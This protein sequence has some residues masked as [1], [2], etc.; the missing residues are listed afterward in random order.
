MDTIIAYRINGGPVQVIMD[1]E[2]KVGVFQDYDSALKF[3][4]ESK[5]FQSGQADYQIVE[6]GLLYPGENGE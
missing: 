6:L 3:A 5:L 2:E 4:S 1:E